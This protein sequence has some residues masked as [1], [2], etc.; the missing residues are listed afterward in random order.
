MLLLLMILLCCWCFCRYYADGW[1]DG[2]SD[3]DD[4]VAD[5][6]AAVIM[7]FCGGSGDVATNDDDVVLALLM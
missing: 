3:T 6:R 2:A 1:G 7:R 4:D 5:G